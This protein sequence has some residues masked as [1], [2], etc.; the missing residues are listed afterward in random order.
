[1][2]LLYAAVPYRSLGLGDKCLRQPMVEA[3]NAASRNRVAAKKTF[4]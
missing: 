1:M 3:V 4:S 2:Y